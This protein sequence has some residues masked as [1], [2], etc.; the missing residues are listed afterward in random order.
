MK[1][2]RRPLFRLSVL[3]LLLFA[4]RSAEADFSELERLLAAPAENLA[5]KLGDAKVVVAVRN[6]V[7]GN[8][9]WNIGE[10]AGLEMTAALRRHRI[11]AI[12]A[13]GDTRLDKLEA[14]DQPFTDQQVESLPKAG[15]QVLVGIE[16]LSS[17]KPR[18][19]ITAFAADAA[20]PLWS[21]T[22][23]VPDRAL[24]LDNNIPPLN[25][26]VVEFARKALGTRVRGGDCTHLP[27][28]SLAAA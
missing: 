7:K 18:L 22:L 23:A 6:G 12:R 1:T 24:T 14:S 2:M 15:R 27:E 11:D 20:E 16:W 26:A 3:S 21:K 19:K 13:A 28:D 5:Q 17:K 10:A 4:A 9:P 8:K 25:R